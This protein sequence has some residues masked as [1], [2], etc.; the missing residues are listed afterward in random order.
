MNVT[1]GSEMP[2]PTQRATV[3]RLSDRELVLTRSFHAPA[4]IVFDAWTKPDLIKRWW[5]PRSLGVV[6]FECEADVRVGGKYR[7]VFGRDP[8][9][10]MA[11]SGTYTEVIPSSRLVCTQLFEPMPAAGEAIVTATFEVQAG[12]TRLVLHQLFPSK[13][14]LDGAVASG[15]EH[16]MRASYEQLDELVASLS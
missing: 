6:L 13:E 16:G 3:E 7:F 2:A 8:K 15:M 5:A 1:G 12:T 9:Q 11:F 14:A 10:P 4:R